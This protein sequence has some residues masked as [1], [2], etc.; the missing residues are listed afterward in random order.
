M[1]CCCLVDVNVY[2]LQKMCDSFI[3]T[4]GRCKMQGHCFVAVDVRILNQASRQR[5]AAAFDCVAELLIFFNNFISF[6]NLFA[7]LFMILFVLVEVSGC[8]CDV[9]VVRLLTFT[10]FKLIF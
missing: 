5:S 3:V 1:L 2:A 4:F 10:N 6:L 8:A 9:A 7:K